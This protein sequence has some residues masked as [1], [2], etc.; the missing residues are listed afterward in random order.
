MDLSQTLDGVEGH[1][2]CAAE[3]SRAGWLKKGDLSRF[4]EEAVKWRVFEETVMEVREKFAN[5]PP[6]DLHAMID[7]ACASVRTDML[8][9][10]ASVLDIA[11]AGGH[12]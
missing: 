3:F 9:P 12:R 4:V 5:L 6:A 11:R 1:R 7:E 10:T 2:Y 8:P